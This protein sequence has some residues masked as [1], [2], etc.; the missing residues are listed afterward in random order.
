[1]TGQENVEDNRN[2]PAGAFCLGS[3]R[4]IFRIWWS[5]IAMTGQENF[6]D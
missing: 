5:W 3:C 6:E 4:N 1:M 2:H